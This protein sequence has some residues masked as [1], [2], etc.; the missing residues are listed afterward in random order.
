MKQKTVFIYLYGGKKWA[1]WGSTWLKG[2][3]FTQFISCIEYYS[4]LSLSSSVSI[5]YSIYILSYNMVLIAAVWPLSDTVQTSED[6][7]IYTHVYVYITPSFQS[8]RLS[9]SLSH[10][11]LNMC[12]FEM[13][14]VF[15]Y[16]VYSECTWCILMINTRSS[17]MYYIPWW[18][19]GPWK[20]EC[21]WILNTTQCN[22]YIF[23]RT[24]WMMNN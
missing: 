13:P 15:I 17:N 19:E 6:R 16:N 4:V 20:L 14:E 22:I 11:I 10:T 21:P 3:T 23:G 2:S 1:W 8:L 5:Y 18:C 24:V 7:I 12:I 9:I